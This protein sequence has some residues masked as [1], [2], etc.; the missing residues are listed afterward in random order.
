MLAAGMHR[1]FMSLLECVG[2]HVWVAVAVTLLCS[3]VVIGYICIGLEWQRSRKALSSG[4]ADRA[5]VRMRNIFLLCGLCGYAF[6][7]MKFLMPVVA[8]PYVWFGWGA[9]MVFL[10]YYTWA[11]WLDRRHFR[12]V[13]EDAAVRTHAEQTIAAVKAAVDQDD[14]Q[15]AKEIMEAHWRV[16]DR[17][18]KQL[19]LP[20]LKRE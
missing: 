2:G 4:P 17:V 14:I 16:V 1:H 5:L 13:Y 18:R 20:P 12:V 10:N 7:P 19:D 9:A 8:L 3:S 11:Y 6:L 15:R